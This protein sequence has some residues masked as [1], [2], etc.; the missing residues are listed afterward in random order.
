MH[1][2][3]RT[4]HWCG[5]KGPRRTVQTLYLRNERT[6]MNKYSH[7]LWDWNGTLLDD[8]WLCIDIFN[9]MLTKRGKPSL[10]YERY[11][12]IFDFPVRVC[13]ERA[14]FDFSIETFD[15]AATEFCNEYARRVGECSLHDGAK[16]ILDL[17]AESG[18]RQSILSA[19]EQTQLEAMLYAFGLSF[20]FDR[21]VGQSDHHANGKVLRGKELVDSLGISCGNVLLIGDTTHDRFIAEKVGIDSVLLATGHHTREKLQVNSAK[22]FDNLLDLQS[23]IK[24][25]GL[26]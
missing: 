6:E 16:E 26:E 22:V 1:R 14:G 10:D 15:Y 19:T 5:R 12:D 18:V 21:V 25:E 9:G 17:F 24:N 8:V 7:I 13:Y 20:M 2:L 23:I 11:R 3:G 4:I